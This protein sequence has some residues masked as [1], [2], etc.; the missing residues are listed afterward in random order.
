MSGVTPKDV[1]SA[2][3]ETDSL[4]SAATQPGA[5]KQKWFAKVSMPWNPGIRLAFR[6]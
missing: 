4:A 5:L 1:Y 3:F 6:H 2:W